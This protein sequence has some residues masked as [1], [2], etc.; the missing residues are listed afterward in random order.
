M[1][2]DKNR[3]EE[4]KGLFNIQTMSPLLHSKILHNA[5]FWSKRGVDKKLLR[6][7]HCVVL[8]GA[9]RDSTH[10]QQQQQLI[11]LSSS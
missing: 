1:K 5:L 11:H 6:M 9:L 2:H 10:T 3:V 7:K 8:C 4:K